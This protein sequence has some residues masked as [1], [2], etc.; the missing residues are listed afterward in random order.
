MTPTDATADG[1]VTVTFRQANA[2]VA[3]H[4]NSNAAIRAAQNALYAYRVD[5]TTEAAW[6]LTIDPRPPAAPG[7][8]FSGATECEIGPRLTARRL[9]DQ[10]WVPDVQSL[11]SLDRPAHR[12]TVQCP[13]SSASRWSVRLV[14]QLMTGQLLTTGAVYAH[15]AAFTTSGGGV[16]VAGLKGS[17]KTTTL[18]AALRHLGANYVSN[19]RILLHQ[20]GSGIVAEAWPQR[21]HVG[22]GTL[23]AFP[24]LADIAHNHPRQPGGRRDK[25]TIE[26]HDF[27]RILRAGTV[28]S[29]CVLNAIVLPRLSLERCDAAAEP[30]APVEL[31]QTLVSTRM[32]MVNPAAGYAAHINHWLGTGHSTDRDIEELADHIAATVPGFRLHLGTCPQEVA[33]VLGELTATR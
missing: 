13:D 28:V 6:H 10:W 17:G 11:I 20:A 9:G 32:F 19:D 24:D 22:V 7:S 14:R 33:A 25:V 27:S 30:I 5:D 15:A 18:L 2:T 21:V 3:L 4:T 29:S 31:R 1:A 23:S 26:P 16:A 12:L 8:R